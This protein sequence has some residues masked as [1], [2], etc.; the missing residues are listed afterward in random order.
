VAA[1]V[2]RKEPAVRIAGIVIAA[3]VVLGLRKVRWA[4]FLG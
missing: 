3:A 4:R 1:P 2:R